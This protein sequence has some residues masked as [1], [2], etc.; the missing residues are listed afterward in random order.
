M[1]RT[2]FCKDDFKTGDIVTLR[3]GDRLIVTKNDFNDIDVNNNNN[4]CEISE[5]DND[6]R[7]VNIWAGED[8]TQPEDE[9][10]DIMKV[11]RPTQYKIMYER[12]EGKEMTLAQICKELGYNVKII[13]EE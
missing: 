9:K 4:L 8:V 13:K 10:N 1:N 7:Y 3:N 2:N 11:E 12:E 6:L 5:L